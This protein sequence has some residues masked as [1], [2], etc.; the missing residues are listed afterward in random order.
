LLD[1]VS[2]EKVGMSQ[3]LRKVKQEEL[4]KLAEDLTRF[5]VGN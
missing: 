5:E 2:A 1:A 4:E 3:E